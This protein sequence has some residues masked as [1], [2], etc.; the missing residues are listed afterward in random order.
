MINKFFKNISLLLLCMFLGITIVGCTKEV[1]N[2][3]DLVLEIVNFDQEIAVPEMLKAVQSSNPN[4]L[5]QFYESNDELFKKKFSNYLTDEALNE[6]LLNSQPNLLLELSKYSLPLQIGDPIV[7]NG[8]S[9][10]IT[11]NFEDSNNVEGSLMFQVQ[12]ADN[13]ISYIKFIA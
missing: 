2:N 9:Q 4:D 7:E 11:I 5:I 6:Y 13:K 12:N 10:L 8:D 3:T 1:S